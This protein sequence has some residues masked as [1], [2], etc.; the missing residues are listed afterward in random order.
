MCNHKRKGSDLSDQQAHQNDHKSWSRRSF[1]STLGVG[2]GMSMVLGKMPISAIGASPLQAALAGSETDRVLVILRLKGGNDGL[3]TIVPLYDYD[4]YQ[5]QR[6]TLAIPTNE[7]INLSDE[8]GMPNFMSGL[9]DLWNDGNMKVLHSV[10][11]PNQNLSH[12]TS[13]DIWAS[14]EEGQLTGWL[15]RFFEN[16]Y[17]DFL[18][19]PPSIPPAIQIGNASNLMF[20]GSAAEM[21][22]TINNT[23]ILEAIIENGALHDVLDVP[24]C[25]FGE[26]LAFA[27]SIANTTF[28]YAETIKD[29]YDASTTNANYFP[30]LANNDLQR[31]GTQLSIVARLIKGNLGTKIYMVELGGFDTHEGQAEYHPSL[32]EAVA[33]AVNAF[34]IDL[35][36][37]DQSQNV[38][39]MTVSEFG[40]RI[41]ENGSLGT[42]H[43]ASAPLFFFGGELA[44]SDSNFIG[45]VPDLNNPDEEGNLQ[46]DTD[47]RN[48]YATVL[49]NWLCID[50]E[51][52][53]AV[54]GQSHDRLDDLVVACGVSTGT[55]SN[56]SSQHP[57]THQAL[58]NKDGSIMIDYQLPQS[59]NVKVEIYSLLGRFITT[60]HDGP[61]ASGRHQIPFR[62]NRLMRGHYVYRIV[63]NQHA[64]SN[65]FTLM[66]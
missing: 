32:M 26:Q 61:Q 52:V 34:Y 42:D 40:R 64:Y 47:F 38:L 51:T 57:L 56:F 27:R 14:A 6:P 36:A 1:L 9:N 46:F 12:F 39:T 60:L 15:G 19:N 66:K 58:Y 63:V 21:G 10:G 28:I 43:G 18:V 45:E 41:E 35:A 7:I 25:Y 37:G 2:A 48:I 4:N 65:K 44:N 22:L 31:L 30:N 54:M 5:S 62:P 20:K 53:D 59:A 3:N 11:Y 50:P 29:A 16:E 49:E 33:E 13:S 8:I 55:Y 17:P 23:D 24:D